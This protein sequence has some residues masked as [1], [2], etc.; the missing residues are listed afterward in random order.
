[1]QDSEVRFP[2]DWE[3][4]VAHV[5]GAGSD[6]VL[7]PEMPFAPWFAVTQP[8]E[9]ALWHAAVAAHERWLPR[10]TQLAPAT[11]L[12]TRPVTQAGVRR[13]EAFVWTADGGYRAAHHKYYLPNEDGFFEASWYSRGDGTFA[14]QQC[15]AARVGFQVCTELWALEQSAVY[16]RQG[17]HIIAI[18]RATPFATIGKW[19]VGGR[20]AAVCAGA[21]TI[22][23][24]H[25]SEASDTVHLGGQGWIVAPDGDVL[26]LTS[27]EQPIVTADIDL[28]VADAAKTTYPRYVFR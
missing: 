21:Y 27:R 23:S 10:L 6:L 26:A 3:R 25:V 5:A 9:A 7:L 14:V 1:M 22:S 4:L 12:G 20:A 19:L 8:Y 11:V 18:P 28:A 24:N 16:G 2:A 17:T 13:N 15:G